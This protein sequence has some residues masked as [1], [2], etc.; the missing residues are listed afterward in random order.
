MTESVRV[1]QMVLACDL[2]VSADNAW[3]GL[4]EVN[5]GRLSPSDLPSGGTAKLN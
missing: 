5:R 4:P 3:F 1:T 2:V